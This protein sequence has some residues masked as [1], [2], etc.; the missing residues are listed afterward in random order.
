MYANA[1]ETW[2]A[3]MQTTLFIAAHSSNRRIHTEEKKRR[4]RKKKTS[5]THSSE[6]T[7]W[8]VCLLLPNSLLNTLQLY[9]AALAMVFPLP[10][11]PFHQ[12]IIS[13]SAYGAN[14]LLVIWALWTKKRLTSKSLVQWRYSRFEKKI[15]FFSLFQI[16][17]DC[18][19]IACVQ[20]SS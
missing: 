1:R 12:T 15:V 5:K 13:Q 11:H 10:F 17:R 16:E 20:L 2:I 8:A 7:S 14:V 4:K 6:R 3:Y 18:L 9:W 19:R